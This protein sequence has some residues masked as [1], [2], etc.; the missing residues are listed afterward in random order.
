[1]KKIIAGAI[2][3]AAI[4]GA[5][6]G[7]NSNNNSAV[8]NDQAVTN[9]IMDRLAAN[10]PIPS[11]DWSQ[12]RETLISLLIARA[13]TVATTTFFYNYGIKE[14]DS[15][16]SIGFPVA[17]TAQLT[18]P[19]QI[20]YGAH[21]G[22]GSDAAVVGQAEPTG[23]YTGDSSGTYVVCVSPDGAKYI[24]YWEGQVRAVGG[25]AHWDATKGVVLDG[26][27]TVQVKTK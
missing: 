26:V 25:P 27:P 22:G 3:A 23:I 19:Q 5:L 1:M 8:K 2:A 6:A 10:Q 4:A 11:V 7:C 13:H 15:C 20:T 21:P 24:Q 14:P 12:E 17:S 18:N 16:P 9:S